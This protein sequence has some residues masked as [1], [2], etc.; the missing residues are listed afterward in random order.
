MLI[1]NPPEVFRGTRTSVY[2]ADTTNPLNLR[3]AI[4]SDGDGIYLLNLLGP[5]LFGIGSIGDMVLTLMGITWC[6][7]LLELSRGLTG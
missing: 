4:D 5:L 7:A 1:R 2:V 3:R 6:R